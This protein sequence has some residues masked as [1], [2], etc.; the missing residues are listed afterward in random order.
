MARRSGRTRSFAV[1]AIFGTLVGGITAL[2]CAPKTGEKLRK[3]VARKYQGISDKTCELMDEVC[4]QTSE[5]VEKAKEIACSA[6][7]AASKVCRRD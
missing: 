3:D 2:L 6:K 5:L 1:G 4:C 7:D